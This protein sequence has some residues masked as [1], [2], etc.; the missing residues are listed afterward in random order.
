MGTPDVGAIPPHVP[1]PK[2]IAELYC[3]TN[4]RGDD[5][6]YVKKGEKSVQFDLD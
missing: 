5:S 3:I 2:S 6:Q 4:K 1:R